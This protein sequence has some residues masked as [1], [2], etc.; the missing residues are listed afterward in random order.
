MAAAQSGERGRIV[1][2]RLLGIAIGCAEK[3]PRHH[4]GAGS[5]CHAVEEVTAR[6]VAFHS[7]FAVVQVAQR[8]SELSS[9]PVGTLGRMFPREH[10]T[11]LS[12]SYTTR[13][14]WRINL[15]P[16]KGVSFT[17][18]G[19]FK[20]MLLQAFPQARAEGAY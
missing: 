16:M 17:H 1:V 8:S 13:K 4:G 7:Q 9:V 12:F 15:L 20:R 11:I 5:D 10:S 19:D 2:G 18:P 6:D 14:T 3:M